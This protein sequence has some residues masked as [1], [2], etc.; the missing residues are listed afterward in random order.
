MLARL[1]RA[2]ALPAGLRVRGVD[3]LERKAIE[4][5]DGAWLDS[6]IIELFMPTEKRALLDKFTE[7]VL[8]RIDDVIYESA[9]GYD[10]DVSPADRYSHARETVIACLSAFER[11]PQIADVLQATLSSIESTVAEAEEDFHPKRRESFAPT[12]HL[13]TPATERDQF[14]DVHVGH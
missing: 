8:P 5:F 13:P 6:D 4:D 14:D 3:L 10:S 7:E 11:E 12:R 9:D 1:Q 2:G